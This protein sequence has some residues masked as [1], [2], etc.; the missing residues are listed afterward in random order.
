MEEFALFFVDF[1]IK[2]KEGYLVTCPS[3]SPE[4]RFVL[5]DGSDTPICAGPT[6]DNQIIRGLMS[7]CLEAAKIL[8]IESPYKADFERIIRELRPN[9]IDSIGRLKEWAWEEK[10]LTPNMVHTSHLWAVFPG[11]EIS[12][13]KD[14]EIYEAARKSLDSRIEHGAKATGWGGAWPVSYTHLDVYKRQVVLGEL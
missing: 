1:L 13:N 12:W 11:D 3:V 2:D 5:E 9:Q 7:A 4:N 6:M 14:K 8:G 10:E